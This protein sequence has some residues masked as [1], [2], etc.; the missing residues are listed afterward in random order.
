MVTGGGGKRNRPR[1]EDISLRKHIINRIVPAKFKRAMAKIRRRRRTKRGGTPITQG[2]DAVDFERFPYT[3][4]RHPQYLNM[5]N[6]ACP[7][8]IKCRLKRHV[9]LL[10][11]LR[12][13][14]KKFVRTIINE[15]DGDIINILYECAHNTLLGNVPMS[16]AQFSKLKRFKNI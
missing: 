6:E 1:F 15:A 8:H 12:N 13:G 4:Q 7:R 3:T 14:K 5:R 2:D 10:E 9:Q 11:F 16:K